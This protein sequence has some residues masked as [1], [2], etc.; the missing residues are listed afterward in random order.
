MRKNEKIMTWIIENELRTL[1]GLVLAIAGITSACST[2]VANTSTDTITP[3]VTRLAP[4]TLHTQSPSSTPITTATPVLT[5]DL[6]QTQDANSNSKYFEMQTPYDQLPSGLYY[7]YTTPG[8]PA[9]VKYFDVEQRKTGDFILLKNLPLASDNLSNWL[10]VVR[11]S[12]SPQIGSTNIK[13][14]EKVNGDGKKVKVY[15]EISSYQYDFLKDNF[16]LLEGK[17]NAGK[18]TYCKEFEFS[19]D[20]QMVGWD[21]RIETGQHVLYV[22][23]LISGEGKLLVPPKGVCQNNDLGNGWSFLEWSSD[24][25]WLTT[26]CGDMDNA[27]GESM[28]CLINLEKEMFSCKNPF[29]GV[30]LAS[31]SNTGKMILLKRDPGKIEEQYI[32]IADT[33]CLQSEIACDD[34]IRYKIGFS[35][36]DTQWDNVGLA[37]II[38]QSYPTD[39][40]TGKITESTTQIKRLDIETGKVLPIAEATKGSG[41]WDMSPD[42]K[43]IHLGNELNENFLVSWDGSQFLMLED[44]LGSDFEYVGWLDKP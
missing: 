44:F 36:F 30:I 43:W 6:I 17:I 8:N 1:I 3:S 22:L 42:G 16:T 33:K 41:I 25:R 19:D 10:T 27:D 4:S 29:P 38:S 32:Y 23:D 37:I 12:T 9:M 24:K 13:W 5:V 31:A 20:Y 21:C 28:T 2:Y 14:N 18:D 26:S 34:H 40:G 7:L 39:D 15:E 11:D 35:F